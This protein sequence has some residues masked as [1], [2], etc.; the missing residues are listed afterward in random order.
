MATR[1]NMMKLLQEV[2]GLAELTSRR[3]F[4]RPPVPL[5]LQ[6]RAQGRKLLARQAKRNIQVQML[7]KPD[8]PQPVKIIH[9]E[10]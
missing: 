4:S 6:F 8:I 3:P 2:R 10:P 9:R 7:N 1:I 5:I